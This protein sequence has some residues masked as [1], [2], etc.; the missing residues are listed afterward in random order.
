[1]STATLVRACGAKGAE[2][3]ILASQTNIKSKTGTPAR[4]RQAMITLHIINF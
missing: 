1:M 2:Y 3:N 4:L